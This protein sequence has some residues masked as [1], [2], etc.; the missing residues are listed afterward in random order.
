MPSFP[1]SFQRLPFY[2]GLPLIP[3]QKKLTVN[4]N[5]NK[6]IRSQELRLI[7]NIYFVFQSTLN[8][9]KQK[10]VETQLKLGRIITTTNLVIA[11]F[12]AIPALICFYY[13]LLLYS[14]TY[15]S[16]SEKLQFGFASILIILFYCNIFLSPFLRSKKNINQQ[17]LLSFW[18]RE[19]FINVLTLSLLIQSFGIAFIP[20]ATNIDVPTALIFYVCIYLP[21]VLLIIAS[22]GCYYNHKQK[23]ISNEN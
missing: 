6:T 18:I 13:T 5:N 17:K 9:M 23:Q 2:F 7:L 22:I 8:K 4:Y 3:Q 20:H 15:E 1:T 16:S 19:L 11:I 10:A 21:V 14:A 12:A